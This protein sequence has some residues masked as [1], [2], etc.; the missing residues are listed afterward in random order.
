MCVMG[1]HEAKFL[2][3]LQGRQVQVTHGL[4]ES[5]AELDALEPEARDALRDELKA[6]LDARISHYVLD[7]GALVVA[8]AGLKAEMQGRGSRAVREFALYGDTTGEIDAF[9]FPVRLDWAQHYRGR[10]T[11]VGTKTFGK[12]VFQEIESLQ[13]GGALD[14]TVGEYFTPKG[15]NLGPHNGRP[16]GIQPDVRA[17]DDPDTPRRDEA[18]DKALDVLAQQQTGG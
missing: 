12:G 3:A 14:I 17:E 11:V 15:R 6:W 9:G 18:L 13:N 16:G 10:A 1:N 5:L 8:H 2:R 4:G 7:G